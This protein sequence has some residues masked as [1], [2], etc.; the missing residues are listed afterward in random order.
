[1][2][3]VGEESALVH[4]IAFDDDEAVEPALELEGAK[5]T[6]WEVTMLGALLVARD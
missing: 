3:L 4:Q 6:D 2:D 5:R 1:M